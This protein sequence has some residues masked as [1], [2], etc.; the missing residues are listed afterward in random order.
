[1]L[2]CHRCDVRACFNPEHL[3]LGTYADNNADCAAKKRGA[4]QLRPEGS[5]LFGRA[6]GVT[7]CKHG[8][9]FSGRNLIIGTNKNG[10]PTRV[11]RECGR[12]RNI[13]QRQRDKVRGK[14][15]KR[16][17]MVFVDLEVLDQPRV[18]D[19]DWH[20]EPDEVLP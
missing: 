15:R 6:R 17:A 7:H 12:L 10:R 14:V 20:L 18:R 9:E 16:K 19:L 11:C 4:M 3:F 8:H 5:S 13:E 1:M 2:V